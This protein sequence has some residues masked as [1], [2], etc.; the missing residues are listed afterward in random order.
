MTDQ[1][2]NSP[3]VKDREKNI[4]MFE[5]INITDIHGS[6]QTRKES[7]RLFFYMK[8]YEIHL[9]CFCFNRKGVSQGSDPA[10][11]TCWLA[12]VIGAQLGHMLVSL[13]VFIKTLKEWEIKLVTQS[14]QTYI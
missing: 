11:G 13:F 8:G 3:T 6:T 9:M 2:M 12:L 7:C 10:K 14:Q 1:K 4:F 5:L